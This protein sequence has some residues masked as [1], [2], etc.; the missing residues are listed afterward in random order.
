MAW[1][2]YG[3]QSLAWGI[4]VLNAVTGIGAALAMEG[5]EAF[6]PSLSEWRKVLKFGGQSAS[7]AVVTTVAMDINDLVVGRVLGFAPVAIFSRAFGVVN[8]FQQQVM[9]AIRNVALP[10]FALAH[11]E[12]QALEPRYVDSVAAVTA[13]A[14][15]FYGFIAMHP[16]E[17]LRILFGPQWDAAAP[18]VPILALSGALAALCNLVLTLA[19]AIGRNDVATR[20]DLLVQ[21]IRATI[22]IA[23]ALIF[24]S[25]EAIAWAT[26][27]AYV[28]AT[29]Y[30][31]L[32]KHRLIPTDLAAMRHGLTASLVLT[33]ACLVLPG[34]SLVL[35]FG[36]EGANTLGTFVHAALAA[37][38]WIL[39]IFWLKHPLSRDALVARVTDNLISAVPAFGALLPRRAPKSEPSRSK[40]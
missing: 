36:A 31:L 16:Q 40:V 11:R 4:V 13:I 35:V 2:G 7:V 12:K 38:V 23:A 34:A 28:L 37:M 32:V 17:I 27:A 10:A 20:T 39:G 24:R 25:L 21:P 9:G 26:L 33:A 8:L 3:P 5:R 6:R 29:P 1:G 30:F 14:W 15:P 19:I 18:L 22:V